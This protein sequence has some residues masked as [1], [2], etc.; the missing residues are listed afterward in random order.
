MAFRNSF[1]FGISNNTPQDEYKYILE[2]LAIIS[3][4]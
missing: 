2:V 1:P 3:L 4:L